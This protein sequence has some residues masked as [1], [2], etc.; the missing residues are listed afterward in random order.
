[1]KF[2]VPDSFLKLL[3]KCGEFHS[4]F[5]STIVEILKWAS[6]NREAAEKV[7]EEVKR[8]NE[9]GRREFEYY[10]L[11]I[12]YKQD[13]AL[14]KAFEIQMERRA[15]R[16]LLSKA[17][18]HAKRGGYD[19][20]MSN[21]L[22]CKIT[23][24]NENYIFSVKPG[25]VNVEIHHSG[26]YLGEALISLSRFSTFSSGKFGIKRIILD[27]KSYSWREKTGNVILEAIQRNVNPYVYMTVEGGE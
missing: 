21:G 23:Y 1:L 26:W 24:S 16:S 15:R 5:P 14:E 6:E 8:L 11:K 25:G 3:M 27:G 19:L 13:E 20:K 9:A 18:A 7:A 17:I 22:E 12:A 2:E 4:S 10:M